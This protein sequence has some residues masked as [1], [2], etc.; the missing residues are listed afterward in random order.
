MPPQ[1]SSRASPFADLHPPSGE[2]EAAACA[3][4]ALELVALLEP[5]GSPVRSAAAER[6]HTAAM[7]TIAGLS[8]EAKV[9]AAHWLSGRPA[10]ILVEMVVAV[11]ALL[12]QQLKVYHSLRG[13]IVYI[14]QVLQLL[15]DANETVPAGTEQAVGREL[16]YRFDFFPSFMCFHLLI[17]S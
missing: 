3:V 8:L 14:V 12:T 1:P 10:P 17:T 5:G 6:F 7:R 4:I 2:G 15:H 13:Q 16:F 11:Q 9:L